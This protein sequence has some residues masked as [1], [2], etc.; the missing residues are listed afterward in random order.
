METDIQSR[1]IATVVAEEKTQDHR[2]EQ[3]KLTRTIKVSNII[4]SLTKLFR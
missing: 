1:Y 2:R 3:I 4:H